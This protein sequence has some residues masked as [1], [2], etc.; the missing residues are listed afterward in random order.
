MD[1]SGEF[2]TYMLRLAERYWEFAPQSDWSFDRNFDAAVRFVV[3]LCILLGLLYERRPF[4]VPALLALGL[5]LLRYWRPMPIPAPC[6]P[7][8]SDNPF[9]NVTHADYY[10][11]DRPPACPS[12]DSEPFFRSNLY[13]NEEDVVNSRA[14]R[15]PFYTT[16][17][18]TIPN[19]QHAFAQSLYPGHDPCKTQS[20]C[21]IVSDVSRRNNGG[22]R[23]D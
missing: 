4:A 20:N 6:T 11:P 21:P 23:T 18:S 14:L 8:T 3:Y 10:H 19:D 22:I 17:V 16:A 15:R 2:H 1:P 7:P 5:A 9:M 12:A 13:E